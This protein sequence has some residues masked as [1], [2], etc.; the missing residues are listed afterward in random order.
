[1]EALSSA[2]S[3][4]SRSLPFC[5]NNNWYL[6]RSRL[7]VI[8]VSLSDICCVIFADKLWSF[9]ICMLIF[10]IFV[11]ILKHNGKEQF[12]SVLIS[13]YTTRKYTTSANLVNKVFYVMAFDQVQWATLCWSGL[14]VFQFCQTMG[15]KERTLNGCKSVFKYINIH[16]STTINFGMWPKK[17]SC[18]NWNMRS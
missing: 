7:S 1:M 11:H 15:E 9:S 14:L 3:R 2:Y 4:W 13:F 18:I 10:V 5:T 6:I 8:I 17:I 16:T 12:V